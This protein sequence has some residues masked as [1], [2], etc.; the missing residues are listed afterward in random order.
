MDV[1]D[2]YE[3]N[4]YVVLRNLVSCDLIDTLLKLYSEQILPSNYPFFRQNTNAYEPNKL[5][6]FGYVE[7]SFLDIHD[8]KKFQEFS[9]IAKEIFC[10]DSIQNALRQITGYSSF[11]L[12]QSMLF[13]ANTET[14]PHQDWYYLDTV[15]N[16]HLIAS[17]IALENIEETAGRFYI[18]PKSTNVE[19]HSDIP[20]I[21]H[22]KWISRIKEYVAANQDRIVAPALNK[23]DVLF[24]NSRTIHGA[25][26][27]INRKFSRK[28]LTAHYIPSNYKFGNLFTTKDYISYK[29]YKGIKLYRNQPDYSLMN[30]IIFSVKTTVY[31][32]PILVQSLRRIQALVRKVK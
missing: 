16:G 20:N 10:S 24:W 30:K 17:W 9:T 23:G 26:P 7:Q 21:S 12:M 19:L 11:N 22:S 14:P 5:N 4:G 6:E 2:Y 3:T 28:S 29:I 25:L 15:P 31:D 32:F 27:T 13:D 18:I 8:Y 1:R